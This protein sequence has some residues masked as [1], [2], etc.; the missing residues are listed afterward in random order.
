MPILEPQAK[1]V[2]TAKVQITVE[3]PDP[4]RAFQIATELIEQVTIGPY[5]GVNH[6]RPVI[7]QA[8][9]ERQDPPGQDGAS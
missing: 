6:S 4:I 8:E 9:V 7:L 3:H 1:H 2:Y 5:D